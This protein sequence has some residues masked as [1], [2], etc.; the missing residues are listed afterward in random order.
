MFN[1]KLEPNYL[2]LGFL[3]YFCLRGVEDMRNWYGRL[4]NRMD[5]D[6]NE[7]D[8]V[9]ERGHLGVNEKPDARET[10]RDPQG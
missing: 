7:R 10:P 2:S 8:T 4:G 5:L 1:L 6:S 3:I 9:I